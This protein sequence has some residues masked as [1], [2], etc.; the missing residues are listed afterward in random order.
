MNH[1]RVITLSIVSL[2]CLV[3][4]ALGAAWAGEGG[5]PAAPAE[6]VAVDKTTLVDDVETR[7]Y[8]G[9][10]VSSASVTLQPRVSGELIRLGF[11]EGEVVRKGQ[12]LAEIDPVR[13]EAEVKN[14]E[15]R[16][17]ELQARLAY[18]ELSHKRNVELYR[19]KAVTMDAMDSTEAE[20]AA[21]RAAL[22]AA[23]AQLI[24]TQDD[25]KNTKIVAPIDG[26]IGV[27]SF[28]EGNYLT[29][30]SGGIAT[31][32]QIDPLRV[33]FSLSNRDYLD[34]FGDE[35]ALKNHALIRLKLADDKEYALSGKVEFI[36]NLANVRTDSLQIYAKFDNPEGKLIPGS[37]VSVLLSREKEGKLVAIS[38]SAVMHDAKS[39]YVYVVGDGNTVERREV[40]LGSGTGSLQTIKSGLAAGETVV[41]DGMHKTMPGAVIEPEFV[42]AAST[43]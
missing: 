11:D 27:V 10:V 15:A 38:P 28:T 9:H 36:D 24:T 31:I 5:R 30:N 3:C 39:A 21:A 37:S 20:Q 34:M 18:A 1:S 32:I 16:I 41:V 25:L 12:V 19:Q 14:A 35:D 6:L 7:R 4:L 43:F 2:A 8:S 42:A 22:L 13:Y 40:T 29:P 33:R 17:A 23:E 26:K